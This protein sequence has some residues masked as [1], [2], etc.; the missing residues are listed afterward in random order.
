MR[1]IAL[2]VLLVSLV[3]VCGCDDPVNTEPTVEPATDPMLKLSADK[4]RE[5]ALRLDALNLHIAEQTAEGIVTLPFEDGTVTEFIGVAY[6]Q[7]EGP[8]P[9]TSMDIKRYAALGGIWWD[10]G[11]THRWIGIDNPLS[12]CR[13]CPWDGTYVIA[14]GHA[15]ELC[16]VLP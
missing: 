16:R 13:T 4:C 7:H 3:A 6:K 10:H 9:Q 8:S 12:A 14:W 11:I 2:L 15:T 5:K 1:K